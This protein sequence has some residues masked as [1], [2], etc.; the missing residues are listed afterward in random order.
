MSGRSI[1]KSWIFERKLDDDFARI[2]AVLKAN[3]QSVV[4]G[5]GFFLRVIVYLDGRA[6]WMDEVVVVG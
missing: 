1:L 3:P 5:L 2:W 4:L 6:F